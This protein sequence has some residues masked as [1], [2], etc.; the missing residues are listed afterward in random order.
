[1]DLDKK[2]VIKDNLIAVIGVHEA[3]GIW[4]RAKDILR[5]IEARY[6]NLSKGQRLHAEY[7][8]PAAAIQLAIKEIKGDL[9]IFSCGLYAES[10]RCSYI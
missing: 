10:R 1:M 2:K 7:I 8:F 9:E 4:K 6:P 5:E 3:E